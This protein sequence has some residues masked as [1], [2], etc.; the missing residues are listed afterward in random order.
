M[1]ESKSPTYW[2][3]RVVFL[4]C[5][6]I[7]YAVAFLIAL[8]QNEGLIGDLGL[9]PASSFLK[10][11]KT[12]IV[13]N[14]DNERNINKHSNIISNLPIEYQLLLHHPTVFWLLEPSTFNQTLISRIGLTISLVIAYLGSANMFLLTLLWIL[15]SSVVNIG[16]TWYSFGWE[17]QLLETGFLAIFMVPYISLQRYPRLCPM[18]SVVIFGYIWLL[19]RIMLGAGLIKIRGDECWRDLTCMHYHYQTQPVPNPFSHLF[20]FN[21]DGIH[22]F[23]TLSNHLIEL[24]L[25]WLLLFSRPYRIF[26]ALIQI[27]FQAVLIC[28]GNLSFL[29]WLTALPTIM[30]F[31]DHCLSFLFSED[32]QARAQLTDMDYKN[33]KGWFSAMYAYGRGLVSLCVFVLITCLSVPVVQNLLSQNQSMNSSFDA[34]RI[35]NT[36]GAFG[37]ITKTRHEV[38]FQGTFDTAINENTKWFDFEFNCKPGDIDRRPCLIS[39]YHYRIDWLMWFAAFQNY[40]QCPWIVHIA[41]KLLTADPVLTHALLSEPTDESP[42]YNSNATC[43]RVFPLV[44]DRFNSDGKLLFAAPV[45][46]RAELYEYIFTPK[47][48]LGTVRTVLDNSTSAAVSRWSPTVMHKSTDWETGKWWSRR[49]ARSYLPIV[50]LQ[51]ESLKTFLMHHEMLI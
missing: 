16:Q 18:P 24:V 3:T 23:E 14:I 15:Y 42:F 48:H 41:Y 32:D 49:W 19:F 36:Y 28:S 46:V 47:T 10:R 30:C 50:N 34:F 8:N 33:R 35:V 2:L 51:D 37:T 31:D 29:N 39:P 13:A 27:I 4:R 22:V 25:P 17:S 20:H 9:T 40:Q 7:I 45:H 5:L 43:S 1:V 12:N 26:G 44:F 38:I 6:A 11:L 21:P